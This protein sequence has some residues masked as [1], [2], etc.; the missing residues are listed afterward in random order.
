MGCLIRTLKTDGTQGSMK[1]ISLAQK[2]VLDGVLW[3][4]KDGYTNVILRTVLWKVL[5]E[6]QIIRA[7]ISG[8]RHQNVRYLKLNWKK[9]KQILS[10]S[11]KSE[12]FQ[13]YMFILYTLIVNTQL[14]C[15]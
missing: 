3:Y 7:N 15:V 12:I 14:I 5:W 4:T 10:N 6:A 11:I 13:L 9:E 2:V 1:N 8:L